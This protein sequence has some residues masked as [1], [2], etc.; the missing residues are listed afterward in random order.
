MIGVDS[1]RE[2]EV[3]R[4]GPASVDTWSGKD[5]L[6]IFYR[7]RT[8]NL[9]HAE[10]F[11]IDPV[12]VVRAVASR[13]SETPRSGARW[14]KMACIRRRFRLLGGVDHR[15]D[16]PEGALIQHASDLGVIVRRHSCHRDSRTS[17]DCHECEECLM[18]SP[19]A[20]L[21]FHQ[22]EVDSGAA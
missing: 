19:S 6:G 2:C 1:H 15:D 4:A 10:N 12:S 21:L 18:L 20:V 8:F 14:R 7:R 16:D 11:V 17:L 9:H 5:C 22:N 3:G 13:P